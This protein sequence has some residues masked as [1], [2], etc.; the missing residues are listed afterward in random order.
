MLQS[1]AFVGQMLP[2]NLQEVRKSLKRDEGHLQ[3]PQVIYNHILISFPVPSQYDHHVKEKLTSWLLSRCYFC[4][5][6]VSERLQFCHAEVT[7]LGIRCGGPGRRG[8]DMGR[9]TNL[10]CSKQILSR[11]ALKKF[12]PFWCDLQK[13]LVGESDNQGPSANILLIS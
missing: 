10:A 7:T 12:H 8:V 5:T 6:S 2:I 3:K 1:L 4:K 13:L 11:T 9:W